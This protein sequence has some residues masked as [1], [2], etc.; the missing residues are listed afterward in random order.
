M[1]QKPTIRNIFKWYDP[2]PL[3]IS[4][5]VVTT[6]AMLI[7]QAITSNGTIPWRAA[8]VAILFYAITNQV[9]GLI[10]KK[11]VQYTLISYACFTLLMIIL[12]LLAGKIAQTPLSQLFY[13][14]RLYLLLVVFYILETILAVVFRVMH[15]M[16]RGDNKF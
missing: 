12:L 10:S 11:W 7:I 9:S 6:M 14:R 4:L 3:T 2:L 5:I 1:E 16:V 15:M 8:A 13:M